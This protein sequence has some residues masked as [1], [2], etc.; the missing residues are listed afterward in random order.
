MG[1]V[2]QTFFLIT[3][4]IAILGGAWMLFR[5]LPVLWKGQRIDGV[6]ESWERRRDAEFP[7]SFHY[8]P[9]VRFEDTKGQRHTVRIDRGYNSEKFPVGA[10]YP[11]RFDPVNPSRAYAAHP[12]NM[13]AGAILLIVLGVAAIYAATL[14]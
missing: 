11:I 1:G 14:T 13:L 10:P 6:V 7:D 12:G 5:R 4:L 2:I 8:F 3:G 9:H